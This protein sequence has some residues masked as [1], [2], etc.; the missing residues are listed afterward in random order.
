ME[1]KRADRRSAAILIDARLA[2][3]VTTPLVIMMMSVSLTLV[4]PVLATAA[5]A[6]GS[7]ND[8]ILR[9]GL[10]F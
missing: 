2:V 4:L 5:V 10:V 9:V 7:V 6:V 1:H 8:L 3:G